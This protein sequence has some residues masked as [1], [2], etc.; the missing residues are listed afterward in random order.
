[1]GCKIRN[2]S[3]AEGFSGSPINGTGISD[4]IPWTATLDEITKQ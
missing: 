3:S 2:S 4:S 1:L